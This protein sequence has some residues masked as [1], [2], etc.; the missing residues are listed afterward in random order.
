MRTKRIQ[1][2]IAG[3]LL[4]ATAAVGVLATGGTVGGPVTGLSATQVSGPITFTATLDRGAVHQG[5]DAT[6]RVELVMKVG[7]VAAGL[8]RQPRR[9]TDLVIVL[10]RSGSMSGEKMQQA[11]ASVR[12]LVA[13]LDARDRFS[14]VSY[15]SDARVDFPLGTVDGVGRR[16]F[17][18]R[19]ASVATGGGTN[20]SSGLDQ[21]FALIGGDRNAE[22]V[23]HLILI[24]DGLANEGDATPEGLKARARRAAQGEFMMSTVGVGNDFNEYLMTALADEGT[25]NYYYVKRANEL[26]EVFAREFDAARTTIAT[27][28]AVR[29]DPSSGVQVVDAAGYPLERSGD[30]VLFRPG[31]LFA[32]QERRVW[33]TLRV[34]NRELGQYDIGRFEL[35]YSDAAGRQAVRIN[36]APKIACVGGKKEYLSSFDVDAW[37]RSVVVDRYNKMQEEVAREVKSGNRKEALQV[38]RTYRDDVSDRNAVLQSAPVAQKL[39]EM[40]S[41][42]A[43]VRSAFEGE[44]QAQKQSTLSK[45]KS[46]VAKDGRRVG[47]K[48][49]VK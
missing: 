36:D 18:D 49:A 11:K 10:D 6:A 42:E 29:V 17:S 35:S 39:D 14:L 7:D 15:S 25:G 13:Q 38:L 2:V 5:G 9:A 27:G 20:M 43:E 33:L 34:P 31:S 37:S 12:E 22:R 28:L 24:S 4:L 30:S 16:R 21:A 45:V 3:G 32:G 46:A 44:G 1:F 8:S 23:P 48:K 40:D 19:L 47:A 41:L 26:G